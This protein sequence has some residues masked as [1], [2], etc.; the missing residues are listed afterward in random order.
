MIAAVTRVSYSYVNAFSTTGRHRRRKRP[1][2]I[3]WVASQRPPSNN[4][5]RHLL[6]TVVV[7][8]VVV[9]TIDVV[10]PFVPRP[11]Y[12][13][14]C[15]IVRLHQEQQQQHR[16]DAAAHFR[17][18]CTN[19][20]SLVF[21]FTICART[22]TAN[23][24]QKEDIVVSKNVP[25]G[26]ATV[27]EDVADW[28][29]IKEY[30]IPSNGIDVD[31]VLS[32]PGLADDRKTI[33]RLQIQRNNLTIPVALMVLDPI[34]YPSLSKARK[35]CRQGKILIRSGKLQDDDTDDDDDYEKEEQRATCWT[36]VPFRTGRVGD[37]VYPMDVLA[38]Q[39]TKKELIRNRNGRMIDGDTITSS[40]TSIGVD[41][42]TIETSSPRS[43][44]YSTQSM[45]QPHF[46]LS[47][48]YEDDVMAIVN[49][50]AG[51]LVHP[52][53]GRG[54]NSILYALPYFLQRP[55][56]DTQLLV[57]D[58][59]IILDQ[60]VPV[61]RL[62]FATSGLLVVGKTKHA[63]RHLSQQFEFRHAQ[64]TY[65]AMVYGVPKPDAHETT[66]A[67]LEAKRSSSPISSSVW[68][69]IDGLLEGKHATTRWRL[70]DT[71]DFYV[72]LVRDKDKGSV[73]GD[74][75]SQRDSTRLSPIRGVPVSLVELKPK[76]GR[77]HQLRR[78]MAYDYGTPIVGDPIYAKEFVEKTFLDGK[79]AWERYH[80]GL[81]LCSNEISIS[82]PFYNTPKGREVWTRENKSILLSSSL[83]DVTTHESFLCNDESDVETV[84]VRAKVELPK[85]FF[86]FLNL[87]ERMTS[88][89]DPS[90]STIH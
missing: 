14:S 68:N 10:S 73:D 48:V 72:N 15:S 87:L 17:L 77:Y 31:C 83:A 54:R 8:L 28:V 39:E 26:K 57:D 82:H 5:T 58:D 33:E 6:A 4:Y 79:S 34:R 81:M 1:G 16:Q 7:T 89:A 76:T 27:E 13:S 42:S 50:P 63:V 61:H 53:A 47:I 20:T 56:D 36:S 12:L 60:P 55:S 59:D 44:A 78:Q 19:N 43:N 37:R 25:Q 80:R 67:P 65:T 3:S 88:F 45:V 46:N 21:D 22:E 75:V 62:D 70:L 49:K 32:T 41:N 69:I 74:S 85:K 11:N 9:F 90:R 38:I 18:S 40:T 29:I 84:L 2:L 24:C 30:T 23:N 86:K 66:T 51:V 71:Y 64:K 35:V 52:Q